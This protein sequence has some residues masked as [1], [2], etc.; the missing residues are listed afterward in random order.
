MNWEQDWDSILSPIYGK[1]Y[2]ALGKE[3]TELFANEF[4]ATAFSVVSYCSVGSVTQKMYAVLELAGS[5]R[6]YIL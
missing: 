2:A 1:K 4:E 5:P 6:R 3:I